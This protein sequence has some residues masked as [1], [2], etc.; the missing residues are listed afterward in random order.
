MVLFT[1]GRTVTSISAFAWTP[2]LSRFQRAKSGPRSGPRFPV[3]ADR[4]RTTGIKGDQ[5][6]RLPK[7][8]SYRPH[9]EELESR[10][11]LSA[12][13]TAF[14]SRGVGGGGSLY[15]PKHQPD[16]REQLVDFDRHE[17]GVPL[18]QWRRR[19]GKRRISTSF[20]VSPTVRSSSPRS[21]AS[22]TPSTVPPAPR[23]R[24]ATAVR[25]AD[26]PHRPTYGSRL[27][28]FR[29]RQ[30]SQ[31]SVRYRLHD[32]VRLHRRRQLLPPGLPDK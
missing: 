5:R 26:L 32:S 19:R 16:R 27:L 15:S 4:T 10:T 11:L 24:A 8:K 6:M 13:P 2:F 1:S 20:R 21:A 23:S 31:P 22:C 29:G 7:L 25:V 18:D 12:M 17:S 9:F 3:R 28:P 30:Q 14:D